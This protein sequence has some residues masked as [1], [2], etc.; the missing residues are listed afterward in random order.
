MDT[1]CSHHS[2][3]SPVLV[4]S[5]IFRDAQNC[6][7]SPEWYGSE[8]SYAND[9]R[10]HLSFFLL[11][12][13]DHIPWFF[14]NRVPIMD[15]IKFQYFSAMTDDDLVALSSAPHCK[16]LYAF[17]GSGRKVVK[18]SDQMV[19]K[20]GIGVREEEANIQMMVH[21]LVDPSI[22]RVPLVYRFFT[23]GRKGYILM[24]YIRGQ[25]ITKLE[26]PNLISRI[27]RAITHIME[28]RSCTPGPLSGGVPQGILWPE[29]EDLS[30]ETVRDMERFFNHR[31]HGDGKV[32]LKGFDLVLCHL[33]I[34]PPN[35]LWLQ[36]GS[37]CLLDWESAGFYPRLFEVCLQRINFGKHGEFNRLILESMSPLTKEEEAQAEL[38]LRAYSNGQRFYL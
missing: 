8:L 33:D 1:N 32:S 30:F 7:L 23:R 16:T 12:H 22:V 24:E 5:L 2:I 21:R 35:I 31:L 29:N 25:V 28:I 37:M 14:L 34:Y 27:T 9:V 18:I 26:S 11:H 15:T 17:E 36:D 10:H 13:S 19:M 4:L 20:F 3:L 6:S 38:I